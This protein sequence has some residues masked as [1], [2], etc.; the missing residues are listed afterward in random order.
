MTEIEL[1]SQT[2]RLGKLNAFQQLHVSRK[3]GPLIPALVPAFM[4]LS[5]GEKAPG[6]W[7]VLVELAGPFASALA[8]MPD[9]VVEYVAGTCLSVVQ[10]RQGR[11][12]APVWSP[13]AKTIM[14][15][16]V[17]LATLLPLVVRVITDNLGPFIQGL[18]TGQMQPLQSK[19]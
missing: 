14:F 7:G 10:R 4:A 13:Q 6:D 9:E 5:S 11:T 18:L 19:A 8:E 17:D 3:V 15:D 12:W 16:D 2:Y 1:N